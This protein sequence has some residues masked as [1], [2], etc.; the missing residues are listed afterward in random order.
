MTER[1]A[2]AIAI[3]T[4]AVTA[5]IGAL[6]VISQLRAESILTAWPPGSTPIALWVSVALCLMGAC[7]I[8]IVLR[9]DNAAIRVSVALVA[10]AG[11]VASAMTFIGRETGEP[12]DLEQLA[13][14]R[15]F[16]HLSPPGLQS[17]GPLGP[18]II[19]FACLALLLHATGIARSLVGVVASL[20]LLA[21]LLVSIGF[22]YDSPLL[23]VS[24]W[25]PVSLAA[26]I[27]TI[28]FGTSLIAAAGPSRWPLRPL[29][30]TSVQAQLLRWF[31]PFTVLVVVVTD[32]LTVNLFSNLSPALGSIVNTVISVAAAVAVTSYLAR[33][34]G[35]RLDR[36][37]QET[38][39]VN[40]LYNVL[41]RTNALITRVKDPAVLF[42]EACRIAVDS[43]GFD[44]AWVG[45]VDA[46][47]RL[48]RPVAA[49]GRVASYLDGIRVSID[50]VPEGRGPTGRAMRDLRPSVCTDI[51]RHP[52]MGPWKD[53]ALKAGFGASAAFP[54]MTLGEPSH[55]YSIYA[56]EA[57]WFTEEQVALLERLAEDL[58]FAL[59]TM[60]KE[61]QH[62]MLEGQLRQAQKMETIGQLAGGIAHDFNNM[63]SIVMANT[64]LVSSS[65]PPDLS[66]AAAEL[67]DVRAAAERGKALVRQ[68]MTFSRVGN[69]EM[70][71]T[72]VGALATRVSRM[73]QRML[74]ETVVVDC[75]V[76]DALPAAWADPGAVEQMVLNLS[77]NARDAMPDGGR[78]TITVARGKPDEVET[79]SLWLT[80]ADTGAGMDASV[81]KRVFDPFFTTKPPGQGTGL[82]LAMVQ[83]IVAQHG[84]QVR[85]IRAPE[86]GTTVRLMFPTAVGAIAVPSSPMDSSPIAL[87]GTETVL[88]VEDEV[89]L[90]RAVERIL[91]RHGYR[92]LT[93]E[94]GVAALEILRGGQ[95]PVDLILTDL[96]M[97]RLGGL[98]LYRRVMKEFGPRRFLMTSGYNP[99]ETKNMDVPPASVPFI[100]KPWTLVEVLEG[101]R[102][103]LDAAT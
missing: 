78:L 4:S 14:F 101:V 27:A 26:A 43:G 58:S 48:I 57:G 91:E 2:A 29:V 102:K 42:N 15:T 46:E 67:R 38:I 70:Q 63:L 74:P 7:V 79:D 33:V 45:E 49:Q 93:A 19:F 69:L 77:T 82:G 76:E 72:D 86:K 16:A 73:L 55:V 99:G 13:P 83:G 35:N 25:R 22:L 60:R 97:P 9:P 94:D 41:S 64:E 66:E 3:A 6:G 21:G 47:T 36:A 75:V 96:V 32:V 10:F 62:Q 28:V 23:R 65:L 31:M 90:R 40:R 56:H 88:I 68:L 95:V 50:D 5:C 85:N 52:D 34:I 18:P 20:P 84:G 11:V 54:L 8:A 81:L 61:E 87:R 103:A 24:G 89:A 51:G 30:G 12:F 37:E 98:E 53:R 44:M 1:R 39:R 100:R 80:V 71:T 17:T 92:V 59:G